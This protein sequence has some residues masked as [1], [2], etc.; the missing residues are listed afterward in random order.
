MST[1][2]DSTRHPLIRLWEYASQYRL[3]IV[4]AVLFSVL[5]KLF[6]LAPPTLI[7]VAV[8]IVVSR[9]NSLL[10]RLGFEDVLVQLWILAG[11]TLVIW[12]FE[13]LF[14]Y[15]HQL[16]WR[17]LAQSVEHDMRISTY[18]HIQQLEITYFEDNSTGGLMSILNDDVNQLERF[19]D[20][21]ANDI[22]QVFVSI[23]VIGALFLY[24]APSIAWM[25]L[26]PMPIIVW[27]SVRFQR[28]IGPRYSE[29]RERV[30][31]L[32]GMLS[33]NLSGIATIKSYTA[34]R[35]ETSRI[36]EESD[37]YRE[38][39][40]EAIRLSSAFVPVIRMIIVLGFIVIL[41][42]GG[43]LALNGTIEIATY[44]VMVF[45]TQRLLWP[46]TVMGQT[47][48]LYQRA[49][50]STT[51]VLNLL[52]TEPHIVDGSSELPTEEIKGHVVFDSVSF[53]YD[54]APPVFENLDLNIPAGHTIAVVGA[55]GAGKSTLVKLL[56]RF[57]DVTSG[58][59]K[60]DGHDIRDLLLRDLRRAVGFVSQDVYLFEGTVK[61][62]I[63]FGTFD[64]S[65]EAIIHAAKTAE[66][67]D[68]I[69]NLPYGYDTIVGER[70]QK[71]SGGQ[72]QRVSIARAILK[73]PPILILDEATSAVDNETEAA[74]QRSL[75]RIVVDRTTIMIAHRLS[76]IR[77]ADSI[78]VIENGVVREQ[79]RHEDLLG[80]DG[81]YA[82]L[83]RVQT[84]ERIL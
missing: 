43:K 23:V 4:A 78:Y 79:G 11:I 56:L 81:I 37:N 60:L 10:A 39:N 15:F 8:D 84:G 28:L 64:A 12:T 54:E 22:I 50:A 9:Q 73:D 29:V 20:R 40:R 1:H 34:E 62:N 7:G 61:E 27:G 32:N 65:L 18:N 33:N 58:A 26:I 13:S 17:N 41:V 72:R 53:G 30:G 52:D 77:N 16:M 6:D 3:R 45:M 2:S 51:R 55:T 19:L 21:G 49:M 59:I 47:F 5:N 75:E 63:A 44:T 66:A 42:F 25:A 76:T 80:K 83:W 74:I 46:L 70:G 68:F 57:Y 82:N 14:E 69:M 31:I 71:L 38:S 48:D 67:H 24:L 36:R 35:H